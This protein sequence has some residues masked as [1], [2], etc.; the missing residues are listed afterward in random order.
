MNKRLTNIYSKL[1]SCPLPTE[2]KRY[3]VL[4]S[5]FFIASFIFSTL[6]FFPLNSLKVS[7]ERVLA[8][9][10]NSEV[11]IGSLAMKFPLKIQFNNVRTVLPT[12]SPYTLKI[13]SL[14]VKPMWKAF[15]VGKSGFLFSGQLNQ[16]T[17]EGEMDGEG[18]ITL[19]L[20]E[21]RFSVP[22]NEN[23]SLILGGGWRS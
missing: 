15:L 9:N 4:L 2:G 21:I 22:L 19:D 23:G 10:L 18:N 17:A 20:Q 12:P 6:Y 11:A 13:D 16:G 7:I 1:P 14:L 5:V 8:R 3:Y